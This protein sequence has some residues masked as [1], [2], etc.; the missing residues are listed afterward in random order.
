MSFAGLR[1]M[2]SALVVGFAV[3]A[4]AVSGSASAATSKYPPDSAARGFDGGLAGWTTS[5]RRS[6]KLRKGKARL[7]ALR[8]KPR[9]RRQVAKRKRLLVRHEVRAG[10]VATVVYQKRKLIRR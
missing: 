7:V 2:D 4:L 3:L 1:R 9:A 6:V 10:R 5:A 8:V